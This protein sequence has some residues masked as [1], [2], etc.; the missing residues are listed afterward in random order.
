MNLVLSLVILG[1]SL[2]VAQVSDNLWGLWPVAPQMRHR[3][4]GQKVSDKTLMLD[5]WYEDFSAT[6]T[7]QPTDQLFCRI[8]HI[9]MYGRHVDRSKTTVA[10]LKTAFERY[11]AVDAIKLTFFS[12]LYNNKPRPPEWTKAAP[13]N[14]LRVVW[15]RDER[16]IPYLS[17]SIS[18]GEWTTLSGILKTYP[19]LSFEDFQNKAC[20]Q[21]LK[22]APNL[23]ANFKEISRYWDSVRKG[24]AP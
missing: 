4:E 5:L 8:A 10:P 20:A 1:A 16:I 7:A 12:V 17:Y 6:K 24:T 11:K 15:D 3:L 18:R 22:L 19:Q 14:Q 13:Q 9:L 23:R 2:Q 21:V